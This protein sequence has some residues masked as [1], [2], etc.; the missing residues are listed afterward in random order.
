MYTHMRHAM[1]LLLLCSCA[2]PNAPT[3]KN[4][5]GTPG[6]QAIELRWDSPATKVDSFEITD[7][8]DAKVVDSVP[9]TAT[10]YTR[11]YDTLSADILVTDHAYT[12]TA[13]VGATR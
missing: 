9:G 7:T 11:K 3:P 4:V 5:T 6:P 10:S 12:I 13:I 8:T 2:A 1:C